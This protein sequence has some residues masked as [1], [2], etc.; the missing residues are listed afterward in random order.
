[1]R[2]ATVYEVTTEGI[3][4]I[5]YGETIVSNKAYKRLESYIDPQAGDTVA[6]VQVSGT[7][8]ILGKVI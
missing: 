3:R 5:F 8:L 6:M 2:F 1:M 4:V 7:Y